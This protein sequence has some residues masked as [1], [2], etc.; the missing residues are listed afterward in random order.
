[1][2]QSSWRTHSPD[3]DAILQHRQI[4]G[5][6][7]TSSFISLSIR[8]HL[9]RISQS[10]G[11]RWILHASQP[12]ITNPLKYKAYLC[13]THPSSSRL[14]TSGILLNLL[15]L[16]HLGDRQLVP[17]LP[18]ISPSPGSHGILLVS[19]SPDHRPTITQ[20]VLITHMYPRCIS[21]SPRSLSLLPSRGHPLT[22]MERPLMICVFVVSHRFLNMSDSNIILTLTSP[23]CPAGVVH[24]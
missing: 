3:Y 11:Q 17:H 14:A 13:D 19:P 21:P 4:H 15:Y 20:S 6:S 5:D 7:F 24:S 1:V 12:S 23:G 16:F 8:A 2:I 18:Y 22:S 9:R 10:S